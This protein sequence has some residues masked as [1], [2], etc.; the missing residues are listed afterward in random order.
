MED[1]TFYNFRK[2]IRPLFRIPN[3]RK[4]RSLFPSDMSILN[5]K[6]TFLSSWFQ[7]YF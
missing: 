6:I 1:T 4:L 7:K 5:C 2:K 3:F